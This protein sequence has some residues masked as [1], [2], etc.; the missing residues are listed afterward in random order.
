MPKLNTW[1]MSLH[2]MDDPDSNEHWVDRAVFT[3]IPEEAALIALRFLQ[4][5]VGTRNRHGDD[6][7]QVDLGRVVFRVEKS[8]ADGSGETV[9]M[10]LVPFADEPTPG[11][12]G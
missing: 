3:V 9:A 1:S 5:A 10:D 11:S 4:A 8:P 6:V 7:V 12:N 2:M